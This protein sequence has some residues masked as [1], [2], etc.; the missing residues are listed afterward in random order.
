VQRIGFIAIS[1][2]ENPARPSRKARTSWILAVNYGYWRT[3]RLCKI[4]QGE[5]ICAERI[6]SRAAPVQ[7]VVRPAV[8]EQ[9]IE[10]R[11]IRCSGLQIAGGKL[12]VGPKGN[13]DPIVHRG[14]LAKPE[15]KMLVRDNR[16][17]E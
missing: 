14:V 2:L 8:R 17:D 12:G 5:R 16:G 13:I 15:A 3:V 10:H 11:A 1:P 9:R 4:G 6:A 7:P